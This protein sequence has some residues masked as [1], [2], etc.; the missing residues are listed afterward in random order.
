[1]DITI[2]QCEHE[3][4]KKVS[5]VLYLDDKQYKNNDILLGFINDIFVEGRLHINE[6]NLYFLQH[7]ENG[8][9]PNS[10]AM[11]NF[12]KSWEFSVNTSQTFTSDV[13]LFNYKKEPDFN[14]EE[15]ELKY[16][17]PN[18]I[19]DGY[20]NFVKKSGNQILFRLKD[21]PHCCGAIILSDFRKNNNNVYNLSDEEIKEIDSFLKNNMTSNKIVYLL[22]NKE[23]EAITFLTEKLNFKIIDEFKN[24]N[25]FNIIK[26][27]SRNDTP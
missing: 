10:G 19:I 4:I 27:L 12:S 22:K 11:L 14:I 9:R 25:T 15:L 21:F 23:S 6:S 3:E 13:K 18:F 5:N 8:S 20:N 26:I 17:I 24:K 1:M 16:P 2:E 7:L